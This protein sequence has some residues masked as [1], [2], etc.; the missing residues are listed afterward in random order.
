[1]KFGKI[2]VLLGGPSSEREISIRSGKAIA[3]ALR[4]RGHNIVE[5]GEKEEI[6]DG[7]MKNK[8]DIAFIALHGRFGEDGTVQK[9]L[10]DNGIPYT[11]SGPLQAGLQSIKNWQKLNL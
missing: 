11:G 8:I 2:G 7:I 3:N 9:L 5:I 4:K 10:E 1:M 6:E